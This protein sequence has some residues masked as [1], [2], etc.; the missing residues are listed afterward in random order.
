MRGRTELAA[1]LLALSAAAAG[2]AALSAPRLSLG[3]AMTGPQGA[4]ALM[5]QMMGP[6]LPPG[7]APSELPESR[8]RGARLLARYCTQCHE[9]PG[10]GLHTAREWPRVVARM[11]RRMR[12][13]SG[14]MGCVSAPS[15]AELR[16]ITGYLQRHA[17]APIDRSRYADLDTQAGIAFQETCSQC[18]ALPDPGQHTAAEWPSVVARM[19]KHMA[20]MGKVVPAKEVMEQVIGFLRRHAKQQM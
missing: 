7:I 5:K 11:G 17:Q 20:A 3:E 6:R 2:L 9:L 16:E 14:M 15:D 19:T 12:M 8:S 1:A 13:M 18:H 10:P 4:K